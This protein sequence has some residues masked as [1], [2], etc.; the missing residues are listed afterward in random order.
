MQA[1]KIGNTII[2]RIDKGEEI[3]ENIKKLCAEHSVTLGK[4]HGIG[5]TNKAEIGY[6]ETATKQYHAQIF[7]GDFEIVPLTGNIST[8]DGEIYIHAHINICD[9]QQRSF[10]GHVNSA[11]VSA[12]FECIIDIIDGS[13][14][15]AFNEEIGLNLLKL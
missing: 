8:M 1:K 10:G 14:D 6:F 2:A 7:E 12:T 11:I 9:K 5:A 3:I 15:R 4:I 13:V